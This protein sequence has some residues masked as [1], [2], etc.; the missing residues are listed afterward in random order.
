MLVSR[1]HEIPT[2]PQDFR[3]LHGEGVEHKIDIKKRLQ[4][5]KSA[6]CAENIYH[7]Q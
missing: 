6:V 4:Q 1:S 3:Y 2:A 7:I 5:T